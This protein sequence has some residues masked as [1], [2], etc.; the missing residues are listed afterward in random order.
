MDHVN[1]YENLLKEARELTIC[2]FQVEKKIDEMNNIPPSDM[3]FKGW[4][5]HPEST[6]LA[7]SAGI[8]EICFNKLGRYPNIGEAVSIEVSRPKKQQ[9]SIAVTDEDYEKYG[10]EIIYC[11]VTRI[12]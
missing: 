4:L 3:E 5:N 2:L 11:S 8:A 6:Y 1:I 10:E 9:N 12:K 7:M